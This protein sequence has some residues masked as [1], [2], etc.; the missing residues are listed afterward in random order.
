MS[1]DLLN[2]LV[3][4]DGLELDLAKV[5]FKILAMLDSNSHKIDSILKRQIEIIELLNGKVGEELDESVMEKLE[6]LLS[7]I[8]DTHEETFYELFQSVLKK[9]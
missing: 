9:E 3:D 6:D 8:Q 1:D 2:K 4:E 7:N 5:L